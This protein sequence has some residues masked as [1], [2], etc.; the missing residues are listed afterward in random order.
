MNRVT[1]LLVGL[2]AAAVQFGLNFTLT[3]AGVSGIV[4]RV[5]RMP[6]DLLLPHLPI[7]ETG[8]SIYTALQLANSLLWGACVA[9]VW[10]LWKR[11]H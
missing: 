7:L 2:V 11:S 9:L 4:P 3:S 1:P 10:W 6:A 8:Q 5:L